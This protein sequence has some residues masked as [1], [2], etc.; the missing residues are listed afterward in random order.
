MLVFEVKQLPYKSAPEVDLRP[1]F[2]QI[3]TRS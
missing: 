1:A 3:V 2:E